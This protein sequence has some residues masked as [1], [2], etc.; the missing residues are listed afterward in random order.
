MV[1][2][3]TANSFGRRG[4]CAGGCRDR[5]QSLRLLPMPTGFEVCPFCA[6]ADDVSYVPLDGGL[7][8]F[9]CTRSARHPSQRPYTWIGGLHEAPATDADGES[10]PAFELGMLDDLV[11][12]LHEGEPWV[13]YGVVEHRY[14]EM[15][16][17]A[18]A[19]LVARW[20]HRE[21]GVQRQYTASAYIGSVLAMLRRRDR[22][23]SLPGGHAGT[24]YWSY[25]SPSSFWALPPGPASRQVLTFAEWAR[26]R[27]H[28]PL[29]P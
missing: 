29:R 10:G 17:D 8:E 15:S 2:D 1:S 9:T 27:R 22:I 19:E 26:Q 16:P 18:F 7:R 13:E 12:C 4:W 24:G 25:N 3:V 5:P 11:A 20:G 23:V 21:D 28:D 6:D 14:R